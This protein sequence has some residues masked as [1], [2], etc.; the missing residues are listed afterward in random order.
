MSKITNA[1]KGYTG[2]RSGGKA[3]SEGDHFFKCRAC[4]QPFDMRDLGQVFH[5]EEEG[6]EPIDL[7]IVTLKG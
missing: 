2:K 7:E 3:E 1:G 6:H 5:H 4:G